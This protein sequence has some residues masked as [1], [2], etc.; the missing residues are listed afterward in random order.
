[1]YNSVSPDVGWFRTDCIDQNNPPFTMLIF[2]AHWED[3]VLGWDACLRQ[4]SVHEIDVVHQLVWS[5]ATSHITHPPLNLHST[6][7]IIRGNIRIYKPKEIHFSCDLERSLIVTCNLPII[8]TGERWACSHTPVKCL[9]CSSITGSNHQSSSFSIAEKPMTCLGTLTLAL[10]RKHLTLSLR[11]L[12]L[13][14]AVLQ[15]CLIDYWM[16]Y[17]RRRY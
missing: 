8:V 14:S 2:S 15:S 12:R 11:V 4:N 10:S 5:R 3:E 6:S 17:M 7:G 1:M 13:Q 9:K 16:L